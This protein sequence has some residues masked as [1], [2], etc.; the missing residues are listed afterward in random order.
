M[1]W[2]VVI[3]NK[4]PD[5]LTPFVPGERHQFQTILRQ[6]TLANLSWHN[7][8]SRMTGYREWLQYWKQ[9]RDAWKAAQGGIITV[10]PQLA[11][12]VGLQ[13]RLSRKHIPVVAWCFNV[14]ACYPGLRQQLSRIALKD[15]DRFVVHSRQEQKNCSQWL[16]IPIE[17]FEFVPL[18]RAEIP[19][20]YKEETTNPF[21]LAM[22]S[23]NRDYSTLFE[24]V[25][26]LKLRTIVVAG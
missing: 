19:V 9:S 26:R 16:G 17:R 8:S 18:Q 6:D 15:I 2:T 12:M 11:A 22:G 13:Q 4:N 1:H 25:K 7:R 20:V 5:W 24:V 21:L 10:F 23:A 14:G 3:P